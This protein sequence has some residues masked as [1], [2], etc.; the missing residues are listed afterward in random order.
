VWTHGWVKFK[1]ECVAESS[2]GVTEM[3]MIDLTDTIRRGVERAK[4]RSNGARS[5]TGY[6]G[7]YV[8]ALEDIL[9]LISPPVPRMSTAGRMWLLAE[10]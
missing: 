3:D 7:G 8:T 1:G 2:G 9:V 10:V 4:E 6:D 5:M